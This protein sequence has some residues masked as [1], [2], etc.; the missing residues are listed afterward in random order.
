VTIPKE[1]R[2]RMG[3]RAG[4]RVRFTLENDSRATMEPAG[5]SIL[6]FVGILP[7]PKR[8]ATLKEMDEAIKRGAVERYLRS[9]R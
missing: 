5:H 7:R 4:R 3:L 8:A 6:D 9:K 2:E 1:V